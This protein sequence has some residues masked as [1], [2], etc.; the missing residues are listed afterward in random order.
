MWEITPRNSLTSSSLAF[1]VSDGEKKFGATSKEDA[2]WL[3]T[4]LDEATN[5]VVKLYCQN[6]QCK[7]LGGY[8]T[9][10]ASDAK[11]SMYACDDCGKPM[12]RKALEEPGKGPGKPVREKQPDALL[13]AQPVG[14]SEVKPEAATSGP[15]AH[16]KMVNVVVEDLIHQVSVLETRTRA[17]ETRVAALEGEFAAMGES[18]Q[19]T[20]QMLDAIVSAQK[21]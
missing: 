9:R 14:K 18:F 10:T 6:K 4:A 3:A 11:K 5:T 17:L 1:E 20:L 2:E 13:D 19:S 8:I 7:G 15:S 12:T 21:T 16:Q